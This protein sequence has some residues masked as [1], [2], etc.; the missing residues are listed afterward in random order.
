MKK[1]YYIFCIAVLMTLYA[2]ESDKDLVETGYLQLA[3]DKDISLITKADISISD[4]P[5]SVE[6]KNA[7]G[8][9]VKKYSNFYEE[10]GK[11]RI[12]L[13]S[14]DYT[15]QA[16]SN[17]DTKEVGF[18]QAYYTSPAVAVKIAAGEVQTVK[19]TCVL[20]N[21]KVSVAYTEAVKKFFKKYQAT[22][23]NDYGSVLF[24]ETESRSAYFAANQLTV[25]LDLTNNSGQNFALEKDIP[26]TKPREYYK[27]RFDIVPSDDDK[28]GANFDVVIE[29]MNPDTTF[30]VKLPLEDSSYGKEKPTFAG[31]EW[32]SIN[33]GNSENVP[34]KEKIISAVGLKSVVLQLSEDVKDLLGISSSKLEL[35]TLSALD[36]AKLGITLSAEVEK[37]KSLEID[38]TEFSK[39][40]VSKSFST[41]Y[42]MNLSAKDTLNQLTQKERKIVLNPKGTFTLD[43]NAYARFAYLVGGEVL[44]SPSSGYAFKYRKRGETAFKDVEGD[45]AVNADQ[46]FS[47]RVNSLTPGTDYE[48]YALTNNGEGE[49]KEFVTEVEHGLPNTSFDSWCKEGGAW[50]PNI[51]LGLNYWWDTANKAS[52]LLSVSPTEKEERIVVKGNAAK[53]SSLYVKSIVEIFAAGNI[54]SGEF[55]DIVGMSG[56]TLKFGRPFDTRPSA[57]EGYYKYL[58]GTIDQASTA[59]ESKLG[60]EDQCNI[61]ILLT[62]WDQ[63]FIVNTTE[64]KFID[65]END[66]AIIAMGELSE[67]DKGKTNG[68]EVNGY[69]KF[70]IPL[71]YRNNRKPKYIVVVGAASRY[72]DYFTGSSSSVLYL[73]EFSLKYDDTIVIPNK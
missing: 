37:A 31:A 64:G 7:K 26:D 29:A 34:L 68:T 48:Y 70:S 22:V 54:Y 52:S 21:V 1:L 2:C 9:I 71:K 16:Y 66:P 23:S 39:K 38:F 12:V 58:P 61:Y 24:S 4:E 20:A 60:K 44:D 73:D 3:L 57:L 6:V 50:Y 53:L 25:H 47:I 10:V 33:V 63:P 65:Y 62:D 56:A 55:G 18:D 36:M 15:V 41:T 45:V 13:P 30:I 35:A 32:P 51:D 69:K 5:L 14:G 19:L 17:K 43:A 11:S 40:L 42:L 27:L 28:A 67:E 59:F 49:I 46:T 72:G 8:D